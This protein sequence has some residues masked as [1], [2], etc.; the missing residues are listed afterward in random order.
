MSFLRSLRADEGTALIE[1]ALVLPVLVL[2]IIGIVDY[3]LFFE[4]QMKLTHGA[5]A[6]AAFGTLPAHAGD[7]AGMQAAALASTPGING[8]SASSTIFWT[9]PPGG[10]HIDRYTLCSD[11][12]TAHQW[13]EVDLAV[14]LS[15]LF[16][17]PGLPSNLALHAS[18]IDPV[19]WRP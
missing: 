17:F 10:A 11:G 4:Q 5:A 13:V 7:L 18:A 9:C 6:G 12:K 15:A 2:L 8:L 3:A 16:Y 1:F 19:P 14:T